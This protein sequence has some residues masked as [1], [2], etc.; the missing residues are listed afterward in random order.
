M[1]EFFIFALGTFLTL[2]FSLLGY[3]YLS[4]LFFIFTV[5]Y[6]LICIKFEG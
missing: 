3:T 1:I 2:V 4:S 5:A 6:S